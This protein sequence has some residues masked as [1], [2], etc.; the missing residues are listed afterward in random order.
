M[1]AGHIDEIGL[2]VNYVSA[3]GFVS[4]AA[5]GGVDAAILPGMRVKRARQ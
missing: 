2:M 1:L 5:I 4:F 3:E